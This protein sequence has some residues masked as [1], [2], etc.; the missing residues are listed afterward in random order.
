MDHEN[1][2]YFQ[3]PHKL[4]GQQARWYLKLQDYDF[5]LQHIPGKTN[6]KADILSRKDQVNTKEDNKDIQLL[7]DE[8]WTRKITSKIQVFDGRK[9]GDKSDIVKKIRK[10]NTREK[11]VVQAIK[12]EDGLAW[13]ED[14]MVY[15]EGRIY[16]PNNKDLKEEILREHHDPANVRHPGQHR[17]Q[18]LIKR[19][20]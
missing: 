20:Y 19:T 8:M 12:R 9:K 17:I 15:M 13:E 11:E 3:E 16:I 18:E 2:K 1:L 7:K 6:T 5:V 4:N 10:N 14:D